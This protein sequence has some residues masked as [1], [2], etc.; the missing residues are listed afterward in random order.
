V[1]RVD[2]LISGQMS[3]SRDAFMH[4]GG[5]D[6][7]FTREG[8]FG[9]EDLDFGYRVTKAGYGVVF[10]PDAISY[11][12]YDV[13]PDEFLRRAF[14]AG[15]SEV[16]LRI[17]HPERGG[18]LGRV[19]RF[20]SSLG[21][22]M[23]EPL[24]AA[25]PAFSWPLRAGVVTLVRAGHQ[26]CRLNRLFHAVRTME[27]RRGERAARRACSTGRAI[28]LAYHAVAD[29]R[30]DLVLSEYGVP[31]ERFAEQLEALARHG[32]H[33]VDLDT[34]LRALDGNEHLPPRALLL[35]F[36]DAYADLQSAALPVLRKR[37]IPAVAFAVAEQIGGTNAWDHGINAVAL[38]L[39]DADGL[40]NVVRRG[41]EIG[42]HTNSHRRL[43]HLSAGELLDELAGSAAELEALG[44]PRPRVLA[45]PYGA[46][47]PEVAA[48]VHDAGYVA[49]FTVGQ[50]VVG[51]TSPRYALPRIEVYAS[52]TPEKLLLKLAIAGWPERGRRR[53]ARL[54]G[55]QI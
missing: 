2:D 13:D 10:N 33:F 8:L 49:A 17:K 28:V 11:Q 22:W 7:T 14:E 32:W 16:E 12:Y 4:L 1:I 18:P 15:R 46:W 47:T 5:F 55:L 27:H 3:I 23:L 26:G 42:S 53:V 48:A 25:P 37:A 41:V 44:L 54:F 45:Y 30:H 35:T 19:R 40:R 31:S 24:V 21:R 29:L 39:L 6:V 50:G 20:D 34:V 38:P 43:P 52:D 51:R 36:D 9:G